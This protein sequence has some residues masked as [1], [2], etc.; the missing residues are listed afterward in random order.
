MQ[1]CL[2][3]WH[4]VLE[5]FNSRNHYFG[6]DIGTLHGWLAIDIKPT[7]RKHAEPS[8]PIKLARLV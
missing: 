1:R 4:G 2:V 3:S 7:A 8:F 6:G 5:S